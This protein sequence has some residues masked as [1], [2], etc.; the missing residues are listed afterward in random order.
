MQ[1]EQPWVKL[2]NE[3]TK[4]DWIK[5]LEF[6]LYFIKNLS[7]LSAPFFI[8]WF[9]KIQNILWNKE[10]NQLDTTKT[11]N[12]IDELFNMKEFD[13]DL[14]PDIVYNKVI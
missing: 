4:E 2:K 8:E 3:E 6:L 9:A 12:W 7:V 5:D 13:V 1:K 10:L 11:F 14:N